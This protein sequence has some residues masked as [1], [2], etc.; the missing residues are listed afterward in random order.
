[1][2]A[3]EAYEAVVVAMRRDP[4]VTAA[5]MFGSSG[6]KVGSKVFAM[7]H[8]GRL[9]VKLPRARV[10]AL[11]AAGDGEFFDPGHGRLMKEWVAVRPRA[12]RRWPALAEE[13]KTF[14]AAGATTARRPARAR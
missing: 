3:K 14:V 6:L 8:S 11:V 12:A 13:A 1:M 10:E 5:A 2:G 4:R 9:V 7:L